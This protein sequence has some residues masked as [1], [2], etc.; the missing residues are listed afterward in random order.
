MPRPTDVARQVI[1]D[2][3]AV[4][5]NPHFRALGYELVTGHRGE[6]P[7][8]RRVEGGGAKLHGQNF[9]EVIVSAHDD[10]AAMIAAAEKLL[11]RV[12]G[13]PAQ[14]VALSGP[15]GEALGAGLVMDPNLA[16]AARDLLHRAA[17]GDGSDE[18]GGPGACY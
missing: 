12:Y 6:R 10:L 14:A 4:I 2:N 8:L 1:E 13:R 3:V 11:D 18:P 7:V 5:L 16:E 9:G 15:D 17:A